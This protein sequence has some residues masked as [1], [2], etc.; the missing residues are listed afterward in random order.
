VTLDEK[1]AADRSYPLSRV[2]IVAVDR[3][4]KAPL[5]PRVREFLRYVLSAEG[6]ADVGR[7]GAYVPLAPHDAR[8]QRKRLD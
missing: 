2:V 6:Q 3:A 5:D 4:P 1:T 8:A 7:D